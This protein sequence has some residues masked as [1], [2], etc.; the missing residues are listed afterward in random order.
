MPKPEK[1][2]RPA[3][4]K[5]L[6]AG[7]SFVFFVLL[8]S[9]FFGKRGW[10]EIYRTGRKQVELQDQVRELR[11]KKERLQKDIEELRTNPRAVEFKAREKLWLMAPDE[12]VIVK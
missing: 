5:A 4:R 10:L 2:F 7:L 8:I 9:A 6:I 3:P 1:S 12:I 11:R